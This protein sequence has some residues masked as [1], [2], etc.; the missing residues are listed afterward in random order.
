MGNLPEAKAKLEQALERAK[1][2][3]EHDF[4]YY[5]SI[6]V[7]MN[8]NLARL[9]EEMCEFDKADKMYKDILKEHPNYVDC[10][11]RIGCMARDKGLIFVAS[12]YF[13]DAQKINMNHPDTRS[14]LGNLHLAKMQWTLAEKNFEAIMKQRQDPYAL[15]AR[16]NYFLQCVHQPI[17]DKNKD[18]ACLATA[19]KTFSDVL[20]IDAKNIWAANGIGAVLAHKGN[21]A[22]HHLYFNT[23]HS[24]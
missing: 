24:V 2:E 12:D 7:T 22:C 16:G 1:I 8:Y 13:K 4:Q 21:F 17:R 18:K 3:A 20:R 14:L 9:Y 19:Q 11:L 15:I 6:S 23:Y 10:Y 5:D